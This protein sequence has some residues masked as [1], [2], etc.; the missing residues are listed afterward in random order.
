M[1]AGGCCRLARLCRTAP[2]VV[3]EFCHAYPSFD[4]MN[5]GRVNDPPPMRILDA[6]VMAPVEQTTAA[7]ISASPLYA[8]A[9]SR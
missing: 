5:I 6:S 8:S 3:F 4:G 7:I 1:N 9:S 2:F